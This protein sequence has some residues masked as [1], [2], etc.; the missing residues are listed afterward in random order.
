MSTAPS[1]LLMNISLKLCEKMEVV[2]AN[3]MI[4]NIGIFDRRGERKNMRL[5]LSGYNKYN[6]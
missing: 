3:K 5:G 1:S 4:N 6:H 2:E